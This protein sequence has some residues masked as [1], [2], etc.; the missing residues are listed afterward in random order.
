MRFKVF[1]SAVAAASCLCLATAALAD[2]AS[3][4]NQLFR[5]GRT[6]EALSKA[7]QVIAANPRDA[8]TRFLK[9]VMLT[10]LHREN[11]AVDVFVRLTDDYPELPEPFNNLAVIYASRGDYEQARA[12]LETAIR[13]NPRYATAYENLGD[14]YAKLA[15]QSYSKAVALDSGNVSAP[16]KLEIIRKAFVTSPPTTASA[17][18]AAASAP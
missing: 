17:P 5:A 7:D 2:D 11:E 1:M 15:S 18:G 6:T 4:I 12:A 10:D 8:Q 3:D 13:N 14:V 9:G 16:P